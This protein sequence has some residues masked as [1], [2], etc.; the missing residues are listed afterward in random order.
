MS[1]VP[2][3]VLAEQKTMSNPFVRTPNYTAEEEVHLAERPIQGMPFGD[4]SSLPRSV[5]RE[6]QS[7]A[8]GGH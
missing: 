6:D 1:L 7:T 3:V 2:A 5:G 4:I 8:W